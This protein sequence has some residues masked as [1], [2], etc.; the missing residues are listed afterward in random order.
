M[1][2]WH[3]VIYVSTKENGEKKKLWVVALKSMST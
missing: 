1:N 3:T 2:P